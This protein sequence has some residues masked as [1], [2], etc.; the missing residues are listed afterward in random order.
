VSAADEA[1]FAGRIHQEGHALRRTTLRHS[2]L[3]GEPLAICMCRLGGERFRIA[4]LAWGPLGG[5]F[6]LAVAGE[7][8]NRDLLFWALTP[9]ARE[10]CELIG[11]VAEN[12]VA[13]TRGTR[14]DHIPTDAVQIVVPNRTTVAALSLLGRYLG[15]LSDR[16][17][18]VPDPDL[19]EAGRHLRFYGR[20]ARVPGQAL[21]VPLD[22]L[23]TE[24]WATLL[25]PFEQANL[26]ALDAQIDPPAG[27]HAFEASAAAEAAWIGPEPTEDIDRETE[28]LLT[29]F[30]TERG[31]ATDA[32]TVVPLLALLQEHYRRLIEP[33][34]ALMGRVVDRE[35]DLAVAPSVA[36]RFEADREAFG[37]HVDWVTMGG[38]YRATDTSRQAVMTLRRLEQA[39][40][41]YLAEKA[42][43]DPACMVPHLLDG[44]AIRG[45]VAS[46]ERSPV[47]VRIRPVPRA[48]IE[49]DTDD[50][51][52]V[53]P[54][55]MLWWTATAHDHPWEVC[56]VQPQGPGSRV[57]LMLTAAPTAARLPGVGDRI[58]FSTLHTG[59][60]FFHLSPPDDPP[61]THTPAEPRP[62]LAPIDAGDDQMPPPAVDGATVA[63]PGAYR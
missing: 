33:V 57:R 18:V 5:D 17:G 53:P 56:A 31:E 63:D 54:G 16:G 26:A 15:Y 11:R 43:E 25:S 10:F 1:M 8:R 23:V 51:V 44:K 58:T 50:P 36:G 14:T 30:N 60:G 37:R 22:R 46:L 20:H 19:V 12:R 62:P 24:H 2:H 9:F 59:A 38:R 49:L 47:R 3:A 32:A 34:W 45:V 55:R 52:L 27:M 7:P 13:R 29:R 41:R 48:F 61:W 6:S 21:L 35:R 42:T 4:A 40:E 28:R 39:H